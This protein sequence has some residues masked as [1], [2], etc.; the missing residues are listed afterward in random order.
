MNKNLMSSVHSYLA[1]DAER[2][3]QL[4]N[5]FF[6]AKYGEVAFPMHP[7]QAK[8]ESHLGDWVAFLVRSLIIRKSRFPLGILLQEIWAHVPC[9]SVLRHAV[10]FDFRDF[11]GVKFHPIEEAFDTMCGEELLDLFS[12][13]CGTGIIQDEDESFLPGVFPSIDP[14][15][16]SELETEQLQDYIVIR[17][18]YAI[19][20]GLAMRPPD[21]VVQLSREHHERVCRVLLADLFLRS[22]RLSFVEKRIAYCHRHLPAWNSTMSLALF[23][24][25]ESK[26]DAELGI[27]LADFLGDTTG[28]NEPRSWLSRLAN[29]ISLGN[30]SLLPSIS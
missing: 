4:A 26:G 2:T 10:L 3:L 29:A 21:Y 11:E 30:P 27:F 6:Q 5:D 25:C 7:A 28:A 16:L 20:K 1:G 12:D 23:T 13:G 14:A 15:F 19:Q 9:Q 8:E 17:I 18:K 22:G 24:L